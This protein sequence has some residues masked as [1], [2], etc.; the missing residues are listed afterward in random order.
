MVMTLEA[1]IGLAISAPVALLSGVVL[2]VWRRQISQWYRNVF[3]VAGKLGDPFA[4]AATPRM[5][6]FVG[7]AAVGIGVL[8]GARLFYGLIN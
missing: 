4:K 8:N 6:A 1:T 7:W 2:I 3:E 5:I